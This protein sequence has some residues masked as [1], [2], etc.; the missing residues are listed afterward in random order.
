MAEV[1]LPECWAAYLVAVAE[2]VP[3]ECWVAYLVAV[4]RPVESVQCWADCLVAAVMLLKQPRHQK[5]LLL[6]PTRQHS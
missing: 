2:V 5:Q 6:R 3:P 1:V 4:Q